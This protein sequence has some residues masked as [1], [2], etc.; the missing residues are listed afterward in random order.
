M[1]PSKWWCACA[2]LVAPACSLLPDPP[3]RIR[4]FSAAP[5]RVSAIDAAVL[6]DA[7]VALRL[8][9]VTAARHLG[10]RMA[11]RTGQEYGFRELE[12]WTELPEAVVSR[13]LERELFESGVFLRD[14]RAVL[15]LDVEVR[16]FEEA[17]A[18]SAAPRPRAYIELGVLLTGAGDRALVDRAVTALVELEGEGPA[19]LARAMCAAVGAVAAETRRQIEAVAGA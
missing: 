10:E 13:T 9:R 14:G 8:R 7:P 5:E 18:G 19:A 4:W 12:R 6:V 16:A 1:L 11:W 3:P 15:A 2:L 17:P